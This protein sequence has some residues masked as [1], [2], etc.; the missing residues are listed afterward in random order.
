MKCR[1]ASPSRERIKSK[2]PGVN[3]EVVIGDEKPLRRLEAGEEYAYSR[4]MRV[5]DDDFVR[6][7]TLEG[8]EGRIRVSHNL[9]VEIRYKVV[10]DEGGEKMLRLSKKLTITSVS[11]RA[12]P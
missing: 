8:S 5:P 1:A 7:T 2:Y 10:G 11:P 3:G 12:C 9:A 4:V 6:A